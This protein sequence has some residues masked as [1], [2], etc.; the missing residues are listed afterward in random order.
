MMPELC[1][2]VSSILANSLSGKV[3]PIP[4]VRQ[5]TPGTSIGIQE[6]LVVV[7]LPRHRHS[8]V[9]R[10]WPRIPE[11]PPEFPPLGVVWL[12]YVPLGGESAGEV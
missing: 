8:C 7:L 6:S 2:W 5:E 10:P 4:A 11:A 9:R 1:S 12:D 3:F